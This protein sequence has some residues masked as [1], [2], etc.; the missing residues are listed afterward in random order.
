MGGVRG[1]SIL[2]LRSEGIMS[3]SCSLGVTEFILQIRDLSL[4]TAILCSE[5]CSGAFLRRQL[6]AQQISF[7]SCSPALAHPLGPHLPDRLSVGLSLLP[8]LHVQTLVASDQV[9]SL[10]LCRMQSRHLPVELRLFLLDEGIFCAR[11]A[12]LS[13]ESRVCLLQRPKLSAVGLVC[14]LLLC[15]CIL[16]LCLQT[17]TGTITV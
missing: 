4:E 2:W 17:T 16:V 9:H 12:L 6:S 11:F 8:L 14:L 5:S 10:G 7:R 13:L 3:T 15:H 1:S